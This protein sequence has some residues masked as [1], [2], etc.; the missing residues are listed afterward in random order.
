MRFLATVEDRPQAYAELVRR[1]V[2]RELAAKNA[3]A[4]CARGA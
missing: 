4:R 3:G 2:S 1:G